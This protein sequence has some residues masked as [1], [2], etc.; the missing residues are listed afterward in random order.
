MPN[1]SI[2]EC[3]ARLPSGRVA[4]IYSKQSQVKG[5]QVRVFSHLFFFFFLSEHIYISGKVKGCRWHPSPGRG[6]IW[7]PRDQ[8]SCWY[9]GISPG[10]T[11][12]I[13]SLISK[14]HFWVLPGL[15]LLQ[16][17]EGQVQKPF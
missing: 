9:P 14:L 17:L 16:G 11:H 5:S 15:P 4:E 10:P 6:D 7:G 12:S 3:N 2:I 8:C 1:F 13:S